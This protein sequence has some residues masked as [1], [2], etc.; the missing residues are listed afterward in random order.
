MAGISM[1]MTEIEKRGEVKKVDGRWEGRFFR[2]FF[3]CFGPSAGFS[4]RAKILDP[5]AKRGFVVKLAITSMS[6]LITDAH[7]GDGYRWIVF[8]F[9]FGSHTTGLVAFLARTH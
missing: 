1:D 4:I 6:D 9:L 5:L 8:P 3:L 2:S 7:I